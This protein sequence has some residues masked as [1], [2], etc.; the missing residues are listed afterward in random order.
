MTVLDIRRNTQRKQ[1]LLEQFAERLNTDTG[2]DGLPSVHYMEW[3]KR[4]FGCA[5]AGDR[6][7]YIDTVGDLHACPFC[8]APGLRVLDH[9]IH[10]AL[11]I[12]RNAGCP[13]DHSPTRTCS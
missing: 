6:Y 4:A 2:V 9:D 1:R 3:S 5:G 7:I 11:R 8:R 13:A 12:L 10:S